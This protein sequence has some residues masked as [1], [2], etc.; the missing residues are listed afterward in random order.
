M[1]RHV[2]EIDDDNF[3][4]YKHRGFTVDKGQAEFCY[5]S[6]TNA[7]FGQYTKRVP[8]SKHCKPITLKAQCGKFILGAVR[9]ILCQL[10]IL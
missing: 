7:I 6:K 10:T 8:S 4:V 1:D 2:F 9:L 3:L 5:E